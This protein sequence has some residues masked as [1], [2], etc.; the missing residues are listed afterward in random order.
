MF[1]KNQRSQQPL[2]ISHVNELP[3]HSLKILKGSWA[4]TFREE[5]FLRIEEDRFAVLYADCPS[6]PNVPVNVL[7]GVE[8]LKSG[9]GW[10][11][12]E[13]YAHFLFDLQVRYALGSDNFGEGD[14]DLRTLYYFRQSLSQYALK[15]GVNLVALT[16]ADITDQQLQRFE[17]KTGIQRMDST[18]IASNIADLSRLELLVT[19]LQRLH[20]MLSPEDQARYQERLAPY[21]DKSAGQ[22]TYRIKGKAAVWEHIQQVGIVLNALLE[23][24]QGDYEQQAVYVVALRFFEENFNRVAGQV[25]AKQNAEIQA[26]CLQSVDD[27]EASY[28]V[29]NNRAHK[30]YAANLSKTADPTN[31][32]QLVTQI[33]V[34]PNRTYDADFLKAD[35]PAIQARMELHQL[36][37]DGQY[38]GVE[39][40]QILRDAQ[41]EQFASALTGKL[42]QHAEGELIVADFAMQLDQQG[43]VCQATC[44]AGHS[45]DLH[46]TH[47]RRSCPLDFPLELCT[48]CPLQ[49]QCPVRRNAKN[50]RFFLTVTQKQAEARALRTAVEATVFQL[51]HNMPHDK[52]PVRGRFRVTNVVL[53]SA[54]ALNA[55]RIDRYLKD[56]QRGKFTQKNRR[57]IDSSAVLYLSQVLWRSL[58]HPFTLL[59]SVVVC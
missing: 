18:N 8:I 44:P 6:R 33:S 10:S 17:V 28:R 46:P 42:E 20:R 55:R 23:Q 49:E 16:F 26:G 40:D 54:L 56:K 15:T 11:D 12:E 39:V 58:S 37:N 51:T 27:L 34:A 41:I 32:V 14:F 59:W 19:V 24:L 45:A 21:L 25:D 43:Q 31:P 57:L 30:G 22:Y 29:K 50:T 5:V 48:A 38:L 4:A 3:I 35:V 2:L 47:S 9:F 1:R 53:C 36:A 52:V 13:L 7:M